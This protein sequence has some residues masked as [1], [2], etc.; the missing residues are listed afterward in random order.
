M[1]VSKARTWQRKNASDVN[2]R[3]KK[4]LVG[5]WV[6]EEGEGSLPTESPAGQERMDN[7]PTREELSND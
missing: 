4:S 6:G 5:S 1:R 3:A 2:D 7:S